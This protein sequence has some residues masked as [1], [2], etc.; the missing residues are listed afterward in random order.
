MYLKY[1]FWWIFRNSTACRSKNRLSPPSRSPQGSTQSLIIPQRATL[2]FMSDTT[3]LASLLYLTSFA[4]HYVCDDYSF[5]Y[6]L[7][8]VGFSFSL[9][10]NFLLLEYTTTYLFIMVLKGIWVL[11]SFGL[12]WI[13]LPC[14]SHNFL[15]MYFSSMWLLVNICMYL[16][17]NEI[18]GL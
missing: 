15:V 12:L 7:V 2:M 6:L 9:P 13:V 5:C 14:S 11:C 3:V 1:T 4:V 10:F 17:R 18:T 8:V 16:P